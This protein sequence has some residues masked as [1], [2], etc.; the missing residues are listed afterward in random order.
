MNRREAF[1]AL[2]GLTLTGLLPGASSRR[3]LPTFWKSQLTDVD[4]AVKQV[5][6]GAVSTL[7]RS[8]GK[9]DIPLVAYGTRPDRKSQ[10]NYNSACGGID[11]ASY[12]RKDG[13]QA[14]VVLLLGPVHGGEL[15]GIVGLVNLLQVAETGRDCRGQAWKELAE[16]LARCRVLIVP[17]GNPDGRA[18]CPFDSWVGQ[19]LSTCERVEMGVKPDGQSYHWPAVKR[20][21]PMRPGSYRVLGTYFN[22]HGVNLMHDD[23]F[24]PMARETRAILQLARDEAPD[25]IVSL[26][27]HASNPSVEPTAYVPHTIQATIKQFADGLYQRYAAAGLPHRKAAP[28]PRV[29]G[30]GFPP[31]SFNLCSALHHSCGG[32]AFVY[33]CCVGV[34]TAPYPAVT[35]ENILDL[36]LLL[37]DELFRYAL[38]HP[39][40]WVR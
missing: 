27:S 1:A 24:E 22:D 9:R 30:A 18:R 31:P 8:A 29:D 40:K 3:I 13:T 12:A 10:A 37:Y 25:W 2:S 38:A 19:E 32:V 11:P 21:H 4:A 6:K 14:P 33:E 5:K 35:H 39:V 16:N 28:E 20:L 23:W 17:T 7:T 36:Q 26:H 34:R 15:E